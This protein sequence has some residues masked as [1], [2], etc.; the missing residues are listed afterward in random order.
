MTRRRKKRKLRKR[1]YQLPPPDPLAEAFAEVF[2]SDH[3]VLRYLE[4]V[5]DMDIDSIRAT[6]ANQNLR[7]CASLFGGT[8]LYATTGTSPKSFYVQLRNCIV[9]TVIITPLDHA[10]STDR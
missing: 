6:I 8:G 10:D 2:V 3:A 4:R 1:R 9:T 7:R 5:L